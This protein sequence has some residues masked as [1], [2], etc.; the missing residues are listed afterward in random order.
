MLSNMRN[1]YLASTAA[2]AP[3]EEGGGSPRAKPGQYQ[4]TE[5]DTGSEGNSFS[6]SISMD[7]DGDDVKI[8]ESEGRRTDHLEV[9]N[10]AVNEPEPDGEAEDEGNAEDTDEAKDE[11]ETTDEPGDNALA[12]SLPDEF[13]SDDPEAVATFDKALKTPDGKL[14]MDALSAQWWANAQAAADGQGHL[15]E[16]TYGYLDSLGI[17]PEMV[18]A[19]EAGQQALNTQ[20]QQV[21]YSRAGGKVNLDAALKWGGPK[22]KGG[23]GGYNDAQQKSFNDA[24]SA[25]GIKAQEAVDLLMS[26]HEKATNTRVSP[27]KS[28]AD[29]ANGGTGGDDGEGRADVFK[30]RQDWLDARKEAGRDQSKQAAVSAKYRRSPNAGKF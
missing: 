19:A 24:M 7:I 17:P 4:T 27:R 8:N 21:L 5:V 28:A 15:T 14:K 11:A 10:D 16:S 23:D 12:L 26:R 30:T 20:S 2:Y 25:G 22:D 6:G 13:K 9:G 18:K 3:A 1:H 29:N